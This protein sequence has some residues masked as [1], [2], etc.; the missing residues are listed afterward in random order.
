MVKFLLSPKR[1]RTKLLSATSSGSFMMNP[2]HACSLVPNEE[3]NLDIL[4][5]SPRFFEQQKLT[6]L[7]S[8]FEIHC[9]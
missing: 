4:K 2:F 5:V 9:M 8:H 7:C 1:T 6:V 3:F